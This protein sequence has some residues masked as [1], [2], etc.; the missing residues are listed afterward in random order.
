LESSTRADEL[1]KS[2]QVI[3]VMRLLVNVEWQ[4]VH[5]ELVDI[6]ERSRGRFAD[7]QALV[8]AV[9]RFLRD[10]Q[11]GSARADA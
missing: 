11:R 7:W 10:E 6:E 1:V 5:G 8:P 9:Q 3:I 4:L 2:R